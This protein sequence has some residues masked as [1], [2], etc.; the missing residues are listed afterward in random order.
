MKQQRR[1]FMYIVSVD[2]G[3]ATTKWATKHHKSGEIIKDVFPTLIRPLHGDQFGKV[4]TLV[5]YNGQR[6]AVGDV[7]DLKQVP[8]ETSKLKAEHEICIY[9]AVAKALK[10]QQANLNQTQ[11]VQLCLNVP[12]RDFKDK[13]TRQRYQEKYFQPDNPQTISIE[14]EGQLINFVI[15]DLMLSYEGQGA[16]IQAVLEHDDK[17]LDQGQVLLC[18][19]GGCND[20][21]ILF[22][23]LSPVVDYNDALL[24][25]VL[26]L[27]NHIAKTL[28]QRLDTKITIHDVE[29]LSKNQHPF[30]AEFKEF[31]ALYQT[32]A[33]E[34]LI[35]IRENVLSNSI[36][37]RFTT[38]V[39]AGGGAQALKPFIE[40]AFINEKYL[41]LEES[42][43]ANCIG[44]LNKVLSSKEE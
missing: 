40:E 26:Q 23:E 4:K 10:A 9:T 28:T 20:S 35:D 37:P 38:Y 42:Q 12:L 11:A 33:K 18:D 29:L 7:K 14:L 15:A 32:K 21:V 16:M 22:E 39:F 36:N 13:E 27:F 34:L 2:S 24:N 6:Y 1:D 5:N 41:I 43:F 3:K 44:M 25:G 19:V 31:D 17:A 8:R 30:Q